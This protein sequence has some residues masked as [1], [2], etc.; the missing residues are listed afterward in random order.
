MSLKMKMSREN[1]I[2]IVAEIECDHLGWHMLVDSPGL[3]I[4][5]QV[6]GSRHSKSH[7]VS[8][9]MSLM[10][11]FLDCLVAKSVISSSFVLV[12][13]SRIKVFPEESGNSDQLVKQPKS[14]PP[15]VTA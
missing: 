11:P 2:Q 15:C 3:W 1:Q 13:R 5:H 4:Y 10:R 9:Q 8:H 6:P 12:V 7:V 14:Y